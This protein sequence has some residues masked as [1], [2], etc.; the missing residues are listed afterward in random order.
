MKERKT[1]TKLTYPQYEDSGREPEEITAL[2]HDVAMFKQSAR[3]A[4]ELAIENG[5]LK[6]QIKQLETSL[7]HYE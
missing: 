6:E 2:D 5:Q 4:N 3:L 1:T 7:S